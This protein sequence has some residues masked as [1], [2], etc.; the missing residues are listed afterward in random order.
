[1]ELLS[2]FSNN[3]NNISNNDNNNMYI[4]IYT[5]ISISLHGFINWRI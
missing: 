2:R 1:M 5:Y 4:D 3:N